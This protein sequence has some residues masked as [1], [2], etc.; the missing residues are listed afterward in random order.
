MYACMYAACIHMYTSMQTYIHTYIHSYIHSYIHTHIHTY[1]Q[2]YTYI[3]TYISHICRFIS[4]DFANTMA[5]CIVGTLLVYCNALLHAATEKSLNKLQR[6]QNKLAR[7]VCNVTTC[8]QHTVDLLC[9]LHWLPITS[10]NMFKIATLCYK[11]YQVNQPS[12]MHATLEPYVPHRGPS[13][14]EMDLLTVPRL[15]TKIAARHFSSV[16]PT[17]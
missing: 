15:C 3:H 5:A 2:S 12:Y 16:A 7:I 11:A 17:V 10:H 9:N 14:A 8:Q 4:C 1:I 13:S 6:V